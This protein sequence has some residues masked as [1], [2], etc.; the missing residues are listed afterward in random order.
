VKR[1]IVKKACKADIA[2]DMDFPNRIRNW[3]WHHEDMILHVT[4]AV[5]TTFIVLKLGSEFYR[6]LF[7]DNRFGAIDLGYR[8]NEVNR[9]FA[10]LPVYS[11]LEK[12]SYPPMSYLIFWPALGW[13][14][15]DVCRW[16]W[17]GAS[18]LSLSWLAWIT[19][20]NSG[21]STRLQRIFAALLPLSI[22]A[23][24][25]AIGNGQL[26]PLLAPMLWMAIMLQVGK[27]ELTWRSELMT[28]SLLLVC[29]VQPS[30]ASPFFWIVLLASSRI[31]PALLVVLG[32][33]A[34]SLLAASFQPGDL[35]SLIYQWIGNL[36]AGTPNRGYADLHLALYY[37]GLSD[38]ALPASGIVLAGLGIW[39]FVHRH[40]DPRLLLG[41]TAIVSRLWTYHGLYDDL[42]IVFPLVALFRI[43]TDRQES[44]DDLK[45][46]ILLGSAVIIMLMPARMYFIWERPW[47][48]IFVW[49]HTIL[50]LTTLV[51]LLMYSHRQLTQTAPK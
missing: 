36:K 40:L 20:S 19:C 10:H 1:K 9:W 22:N 25:V 6:L 18:V 49:S 12:A 35:Q 44:K 5:L 4:I 37:L 39:T 31:R 45:A 13:A 15:F 7:E 2:A 8:Y 24:G 48:A 3:W 43:A 47:P 38:W 29:L 51:F 30:T 26:L 46:A 50:W 17:A 14:S 23:T 41:V 32:Y 42:L 28:V 27:H 16:L 11:E 33:I 34:L 21:A